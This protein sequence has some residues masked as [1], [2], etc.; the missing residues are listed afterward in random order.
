M[1]HVSSLVRTFG[2]HRAVDSITFQIARGECF[3]LLGTNGAGK[4]TTISMMT[5]LLSPDSGHV[6]IDGLQPTSAQCRQKIGIAPQTLSLYDEFTAV[7][8]LRFFGQLYELLGARLDERIRWSLDFSGLQDRCNDRVGTFSGGM[9]RRLNIA[10]ALIHDPEIVMLDEPTVGVDPQ[11][12]NH[13]YDGIAHLK[14]QG[15][16]VILTTHYLEE[17]ER[18]CDRIAIMDNGHILALDTLKN[19]ID[20]HGGETVVEIEFATEPPDPSVLP[21]RIREDGRLIFGCSEPMKEVLNL[22]RSGV[23]VAS[24]QIRQPNLECVFLNLTGRQLR[25]E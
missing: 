1:I 17:A 7:E 8:N 14:Q 20:Q 19:L 22:S 15:R 16:T 18:V 24:L 3:G 23:E 25:D 6:T 4:T 13:I 2:V 9:K 12:R 5:G 11:S 21:G 10:C